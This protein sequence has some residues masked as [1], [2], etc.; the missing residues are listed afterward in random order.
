M[1]KNIYGVYF[2]CCINNYLEVVEEQLNLVYSSKLYNVTNKLFLFITMYK[3]E[4]S[5]LDDIIQKYDPNNKCVLIKTDK[6]LYEKF[7]IN[8]YKKYITNTNNDYYLYYFH[9]KGLSRINTVYNHFICR[10]KILNY[11]TLEKF[12]INIEL[13]SKYDAVGCSL[14]L[15]P[16]MHFSGN[17]WWSKSE[18]LNTLQDVTTP[19][20]LAV[21]M[22]ILSNPSG[23]FVSLDQNTNVSSIEQFN[24]YR[25]KED[26]QIMDELTNIPIIIPSAKKIIC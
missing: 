11:Y 10:R 22:Y 21:E 6:N 26:I 9:T 7:A 25:F 19:F 4:Y 20:Y 23:K 12:K 8:N 18:Y 16:K 2:I 3:K 5:K 17:F 14:S 15:Y 1:K 24:N 13:L